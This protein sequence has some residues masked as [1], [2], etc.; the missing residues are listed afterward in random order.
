MLRRLH[1][2]L[3]CQQPQFSSAQ[4]KHIAE[5]GESSKIALISSGL[6]VHFSSTYHLKKLKIPKACF[7]SKLNP[8]SFFLQKAHAEACV[9]TK[10]SLRK[11]IAA[12]MDNEIAETK[13]ALKTLNSTTKKEAYR[14]RGLESR[15][16]KF[17]KNS[18]L[19][20]QYR[21]QNLRLILYDLSSN[22]SQIEVDSLEKEFSGFRD[23]FDQ[24]AKKH[25]DVIKK[26]PA[27]SSKISRLARYSA[28]R[29]KFENNLKKLEI[30]RKRIDSSTD[31]K[32]IVKH[33]SDIPTQSPAQATRKTALKAMTELNPSSWHKLFG[34]VGKR[35]AKKIGAIATTGAAGLAFSGASLASDIYDVG[36]LIITEVKWCNKKWHSNYVFEDSQC[37]ASLNTTL[38]LSA[39]DSLQKKA[40][41]DPEI[42]ELFQKTYQ[43][44]Y[45]P[46]QWK[47]ECPDTPKINNGS[48]SLTNRQNKNFVIQGN[49]NSKGGLKQIQIKSKKNQKKAHKLFFRQS[50]GNMSYLSVYKP[51]IVRSQVGNYTAQDQ[52]EINLNDTDTKH[53]EI[54]T[55]FLVHRLS[56]QEAISCCSFDNSIKKTNCDAYEKTPHLNSNSRKTP[57]K[58]RGRN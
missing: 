32:S 13:K 2:N 48:F 7:F 9:S 8:F 46:N 25:P 53:G 4:C 36:S 43:K 37:G 28:A 35:A 17:W 41:E 30:I 57:K 52:H 26:T 16:R 45:G 38:L 47:L 49:Y 50:T 24:E 29:D 58:Y 31:L 23:V 12:F 33:L 6:G 5:I 44:A 19:S 1:K 3:I 11:Q 15:L 40:L 54:Y 55:D 18:N 22:L 14:K 42:C 39:E 10:E 56:I 20:D 34:E 51:S 21:K 27:S